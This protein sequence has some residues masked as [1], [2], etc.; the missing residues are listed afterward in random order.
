LTDVLGPQL[1]LQRVKGKEVVA[2]SKCGRVLCGKEE[3]PKLHAL[4]RAQPL[5][6]VGPHFPDD[7]PWLVREFFCPGCQ[8]LLFTEMAHRDDPIIHETRV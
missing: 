2:C 3:N 4:Y 8:R 1:S 5:R 6:E 7:S